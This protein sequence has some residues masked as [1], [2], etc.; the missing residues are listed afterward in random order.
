MEQYLSRTL[1]PAAIH[2]LKEIKGFQPLSHSPTY[3]RTGTIT[4]PSASSQRAHRKPFSPDTT[5]PPP[6]HF[7]PSNTATTHE[8][9]I[10]NHPSHSRSVYK[11]GGERAHGRGGWG[12]SRGH[13]VR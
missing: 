5:L 10:A 1:S 13:G 2:T 3:T 6:S 7:A 9:G 4:T 11:M 8:H 12:G